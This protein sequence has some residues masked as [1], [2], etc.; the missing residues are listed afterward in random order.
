[1]ETGT[2]LLKE[3]LPARMGIRLIG[4]T[5]SGFEHVLELSKSK[6]DAQMM[7]F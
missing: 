4:I 1:M 3:I 6:D 5:L 7:L 2:H